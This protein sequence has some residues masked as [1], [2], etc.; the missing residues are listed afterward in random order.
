MIRMILA[1]ILLLTG[2]ATTRP[3]WDDIEWTCHTDTECLEE[4]EARGFED[5]DF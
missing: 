2:C 1:T 3:S 5:C 4:C